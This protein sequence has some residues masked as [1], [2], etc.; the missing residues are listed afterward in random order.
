MNKNSQSGNIMSE[1]LVVLIFM[2]A[3]IGFAMMGSVGALGGIEGGIDGDPETDDPTIMSALND[4]QH[5][6]AREIY[7]P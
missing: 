3:V 7:E 6:F 1:Y 4:R 5:E 2:V